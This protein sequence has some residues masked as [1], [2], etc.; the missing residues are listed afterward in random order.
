[1]T[2]P[3]Q[4]LTDL[5]HSSGH[6]WPGQLLLRLLLLFWFGVTCR[7]RKYAEDE[8]TLPEIKINPNISLVQRVDAAFTSC[9]SPSSHFS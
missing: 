6:Y 3:G 4:C 1:M 8:S 2:V 7:G 5:E 9:W